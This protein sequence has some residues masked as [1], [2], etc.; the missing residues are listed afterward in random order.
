MKFLSSKNIELLFLRLA[1]ITAL[2]CPVRQYAA[3][4]SE[5][6]VNFDK[7]NP[8][9]EVDLRENLTV[10][11]PKGYFFRH[12]EPLYDASVSSEISIV[13]ANLPQE[14]FVLFGVRACDLRGIELLDGVFL[15]EPVD[16]FYKARRDAATIITVA[17]DK[18]DKACFCATFDIDRL[19]P[20]G[21]VQ[22]KPVTKKI[23]DSGIESGSLPGDSGS[24]SVCVSN[25]GGFIW[26]ALTEKGE[27]LTAEI[28]DL[29][30][31]THVLEENDFA[32]QAKHPL[33]PQEELLKVFNSDVWENLY[34]TCI[35]CGSCTFVCPTCQCYDIM[36]FNTGTK[37]KC[38]RAWDSCMNED[39]TKMAHG[40]PRKSHK[41]RFRQRFM[42]KLVYHIE[43]GEKYGCVG[44]GRCTT[45]CPVNLSILKVVKAL[46][47]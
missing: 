29:L 12:Y 28:K 41:E 47:V 9:R 5:Y 13:P 31:T 17:C 40:N 46:G 4:S 22:L 14:P 44:C 8:E 35:A 30:D 7:W 18:S 32:E 15:E 39:F 2:Y 33:P 20:G 21:D 24:D 34:E 25:F 42:H 45:K 6:V 26:K 27:K 37:I 10:T 16:S 23:N 1:E 36:N 38:H 43:S 11:S 19:S 3:T